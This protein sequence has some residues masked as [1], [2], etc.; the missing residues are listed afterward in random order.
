SD[1]HVILMLVMTTT[2]DSTAVHLV[3]MLRVGT[4][5]RSSSDSGAPLK[6][7]FP[8]RRTTDLGEDGN[9]RLNSRTSRSHAPRGNAWTQ[10]FRERSP[11]EDSAMLLRNKC[12]W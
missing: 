6:P 1:T 11:I 3:P 9:Y 4:H 7:A 8:T 10:Q 5:G 2:T 12:C